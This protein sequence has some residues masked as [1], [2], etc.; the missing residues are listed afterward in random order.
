[1]LGGS[2]VVI[3][4]VISRV[5]TIL[6]LIRGLITT[7]PKGPIS[8]KYLLYQYLDSGPCQYT[9][10]ASGFRVTVEGALQQFY[11]VPFVPL[12]HGLFGS[13]PGYCYGK[14]LRVSMGSFKGL[15]CSEFCYAFPN[16]DNDSEYR[17]PTFYGIHP[18]GFM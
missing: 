8:T 3:C 17:N 2:W 14:A 16:H 12:G 9:S 4:G 13:G 7:H 18:K 1:M 15:G 5:T 10:S 11:K 6:T